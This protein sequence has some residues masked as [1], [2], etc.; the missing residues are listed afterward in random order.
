MTRRAGI[1]EAL[2]RRAA[3][4]ATTEDVSILIECPDGTRLRILGS[5]A[6]GA[7]DWPGDEA[8][9]AACDRAFGV[10]P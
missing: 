10:T 2:L 3:R 9:G 6:K 4:V 7:Q 5:H 8:A 1:T